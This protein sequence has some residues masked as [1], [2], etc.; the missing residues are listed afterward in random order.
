MFKQCKTDKFKQKFEIP[1]LIE[2]F[3]KSNSSFKSKKLFILDKKH[4][5]YESI[6]LKTQEIACSVFD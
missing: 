1:I 6:I 5:K 3:L 2:L 4:K